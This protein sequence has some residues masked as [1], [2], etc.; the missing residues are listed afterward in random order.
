LHG[1]RLYF[2]YQKT[3]IDPATGGVIESQSYVNIYEL[4]LTPGN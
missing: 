4:V 2:S 1:N 3:K